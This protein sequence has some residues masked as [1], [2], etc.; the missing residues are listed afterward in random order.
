[1]GMTDAGFGLWAGT[2]INDTS[3]VAA[4][5][6]AFSNAAGK[7]AMIVKLTR[8]LMIVPVTLAL[9]YIA[10]KKR[11]QKASFSFVRI[12][13][14]FVLGFIVASV[15]GTFLPIPKDALKALAEVGKYMIVMAMA[16]IGLN[17]NLV[18]L[19]KNGWR[20]MALGLGCWAVLATVSILAQKALGLG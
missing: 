20:P 17:T 7:L 6:Y 3:S 16:A 4:A 10:S 12:F 5:G 11:A 13:P 1:M 2:A 9:F 14:W 19:L 15:L 18:K 8:T